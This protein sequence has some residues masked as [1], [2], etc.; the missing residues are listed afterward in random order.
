LAAV[1]HVGFERKM[2]FKIP[3]PGAAESRGLVKS[4]L[5]IVKT[6]RLT[7]RAL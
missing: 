6:F 7:R 3:R 4:T 1:R 2:I 5:A